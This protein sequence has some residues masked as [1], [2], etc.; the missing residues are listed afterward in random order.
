MTVIYTDRYLFTDI[1]HG[2]E[3]QDGWTPDCGGKWDFDPTVVRISSRVYPGGAWTASVVVGGDDYV[4]ETGFR[5]AES[6]V[7]AQAAV[8]AWA[9]EQ[10]DKIIAAVKAAYATSPGG[11]Q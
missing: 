3:R 6:L 11:E 1:P 8:E 10:A 5:R 2:L 7:A 9:G 4:A